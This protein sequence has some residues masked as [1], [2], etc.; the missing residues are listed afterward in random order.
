MLNGQVPPLIGHLCLVVLRIAL[1][2]NKLIGGYKKS[3]GAMTFPFTLWEI[4]YIAARAF[5]VAWKNMATRLTEVNAL[6]KCCRLKERNRRIR[7][8]ISNML[9]TKMEQPFDTVT[10]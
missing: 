3:C 6:E 5:K 1:K 8:R 7:E 9:P 10:F 2:M 4:E